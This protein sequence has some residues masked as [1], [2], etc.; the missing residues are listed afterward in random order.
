MSQSPLQSL[1]TPSMP[2]AN[3]V[4]VEVPIDVSTQI[5]SSA[6]SSLDSSNSQYNLGSGSFVV[7]GASGANNMML[8]IGAVALG[9]FF[10]LRKFK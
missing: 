8:I 4:N 2:S 5:R 6:S 7:G 3:G 1:N 10:I 9:A